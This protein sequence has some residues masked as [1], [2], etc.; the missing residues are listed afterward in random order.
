MVDV[1]TEPGIKVGDDVVV[2]GKQGESELSV[3]EL[4]RK[5]KTIPYELCCW[6][7]ARVPR[8]Y[9]TESKRPRDGQNRVA[10]G[11]QK[12]PKSQKGLSD[13]WNPTLRH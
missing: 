9:V 8:V 6:V 7:S 4:C 1:G 2:F 12:R 11:G 3:Y 5:L 13:P 10:P